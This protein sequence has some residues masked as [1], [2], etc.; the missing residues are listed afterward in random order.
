MGSLLVTQGIMP[1]IG[2]V[3]K[4]RLE[5]LL[6]N[7]HWTADRLPLLRQPWRPD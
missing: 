5:Q 2:D 3:R 4:E 7:E 1:E 6:D